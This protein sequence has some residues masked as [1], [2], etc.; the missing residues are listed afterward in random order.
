MVTIGNPAPLGLLAFGTTTA[1]LMYVDMGWIEEDAEA[2]IYGY[3]FYYGGLAQLLVAIFELLKGSSFSFAVFGS[4]ACF[5]LARAATF[6]ESQKLD[7]ELNEFSYKRGKTAMLLQWGLLTSCFFAISLRKNVCLILTF[8]FLAST[9]FLLAAATGTGSDTA[10][11]IG[12]VFGFITAL[13]ALYTGIAELVNEEWGRVVLPGLTPLLAP[14]RFRINKA[15]IAKLMSYDS[16]SNTLLLYFRGLHIKTIEDVQA[17]K[18]GV[19]SRI[20]EMKAPD[21]KVHVVVD[22]QHVYI[23]DHIVSEYWQAV[24][25]LEKTYYLSV[26]RFHVSSFGTV[27]GNTTGGASMLHLSSARANASRASSIKEDN[28]K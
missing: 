26:R 21:N 4:Y 12:G 17:I 23:S 25:E 27:T 5:W 20:E 22:Y 9:F 14:E 7:S 6:V 8:G 13:C 24:A 28:S 1:L 3:A 10:R 11:T 19:A 15:S 16:K 18:E 2:M